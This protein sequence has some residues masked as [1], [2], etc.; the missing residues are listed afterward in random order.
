MKFTFNFFNIKFGFFIEKRFSFLNLF[1]KT[2]FDNKSN[3]L[4]YIENNKLWKLEFDIEKRVQAI[5]G[6][7]FENRQVDESGTCLLKWLFRDVDSN[8]LNNSSFFDAVM[9]VP[10]ENTENWRELLVSKGANNK[11]IQI[12]NICCG[13]KLRFAMERIASQNYDL[14]VYIMTHYRD[15][16]EFNILINS[17]GD[18]E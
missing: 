11:Q 9:D 15:D 2:K 3:M 12:F 1:N 6:Y 16:T 13:N 14:F 5:T 4:N 17:I 18:L 7:N 8:V 10:L